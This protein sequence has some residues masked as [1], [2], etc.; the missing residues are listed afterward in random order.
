MNRRALT[1]ALL[2]FCA[3]AV[4]GCR[5]D[6][7]D[8][9]RYEIYESSDFF[10]DGQ[11]SRVPPDG[12]VPRG[13]LRADAH[14]YTG[15][16]PGGATAGGGS[17]STPLAGAGAPSLSGQVGGRTDGVASGEGIA[18]PGAAAMAF[19]AD[20]ATTFPFPVTR[21]TL[22]RGQERY[23][24]FCA[25]CHGLTGEGDGM[26]VR[27]G[28]KRPTSYHEDR[29]RQ[30]P[31]GHIFDVITNGYGVMPR[32]AAQVTPRDRWAIAAYIRALQL[33]RGASLDD[34]PEAER[35]QLMSGGGEARGGEGRG[36]VA[37]G[38]RR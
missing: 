36:A 9:P 38:E 22:D 30:A 24:A 21:E 20:L 16:I 7:Q 10:R 28:F 11:A 31:V 13:Y 33:S 27:R 18:S 35:Q 32:Y 14:L 2:V 19:D 25:M 8:Q 17:Q 3:A 6:M 12:T 5:R 23:E 26:V 4:M 34:I 29:L 1:Y 37:G 15:R